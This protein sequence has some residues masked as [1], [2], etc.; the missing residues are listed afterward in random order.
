V[1]AVST[2]AFALSMLPI[3]E[4]MGGGAAGADEADLQVGAQSRSE[5]PEAV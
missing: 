1:I 5:K 3:I 2:S 4:R